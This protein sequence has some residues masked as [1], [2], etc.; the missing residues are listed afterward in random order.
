MA[1]AK[2][3]VDIINKRIELEGSLN[4]RYIEDMLE[5]ARIIWRNCV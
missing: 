2:E 5:L 4:T 3:V 1:D